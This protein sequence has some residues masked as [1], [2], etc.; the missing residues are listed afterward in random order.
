MNS[1]GKIKDFTKNLGQVECEKFDRNGCK[2]MEDAYGVC[3]YDEDNARCIEHYRKSEARHF[4]GD[5]NQKLIKMIRE[6]DEANKSPFLENDN[7]R[8]TF[9]IAL[10]ISLRNNASDSQL[11]CLARLVFIQNRGDRVQDF[12]DQ[13]IKLD[14]MSQ[15]RESDDIS[16]T[17]KI[18]SYI[19]IGNLLGISDISYGSA[20]YLNLQVNGICI[21]VCY[22][23]S[24]MKEK[25]YFYPTKKSSAVFIN[26]LVS[27]INIFNK[28]CDETGHR[29]IEIPADFVKNDTVT[30]IIH[31]ITSIV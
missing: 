19:F 1:F 8:E 21:I 24:Y 3:H 16:V 31:G 2:N 27:S 7:L 5:D 20:F 29:K 10:K 15:V 9:L 6:I 4:G 18:F 25:D 22:I 13:I 28:A 14:Q 26:E 12:K 11:L 30:R 23:Y 17:D